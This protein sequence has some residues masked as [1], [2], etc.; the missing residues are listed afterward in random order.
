MTSI[1]L[2]PCKHN[3]PKLPP[4]GVDFSPEYC[5][6]CWAYYNDPDY[7]Q[8][9]GGDEWQTMRPRTLVPRSPCMFLGEMG[10]RLVPTLPRVNTTPSAITLNVLGCSKYGMTY[11]EK[12]SPY[13]TNLH[14][15]LNCKDWQP[16]PLPKIRN[17]L[18]HIYPVKGRWQRHIDKIAPRLPL[19]NGKRVA[20]IVT[21]EWTDTPNVLIDVLSSLG[22]KIAAITPNQS[23]LR[24]VVSL[25]ALLSSVESLDPEE[26]TLYC[27][28][29]GV[30]YT[31]PCHPAHLWADILYET[32]LDYWE[33]VGRL[34]QRYPLVGPFLRTSDNSSHPHKS[35]MYF[36][37]FWWFRNKDLFSKPAWGD[38]DAEWFG[39]ETYN[40]K[41]FKYE[42]AACLFHGG[43]AKQMQ[44]YS[45]NYLRKIV[46]PDLERF[47]EAERRRNNGS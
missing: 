45:P 26:A 15:C 47:R 5:R 46:L 39:N 14:S 25:H 36:G 31:D 19:I 27:H 34:L 38:C 7:N 20:A 2:P 21:D 40:A 17:L 43:T 13:S 3:P 29:K 44:L 32:C 35:W 6:I 9:S 24:E 28:A 33:T 11:G 41:H 10:R 22:F 16:R 18:Y 12:P 8:K 4:R 30:R 37:S 1:Q 23:S 42:E